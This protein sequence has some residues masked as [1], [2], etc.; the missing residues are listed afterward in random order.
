[1]RNN[2]RRMSSV[3]R[4]NRCVKRERSGGWRDEGLARQ[5]GEG[6]DDEAAKRERVDTRGKEG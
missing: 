5:R 4:P 1:M 2:A 3:E 6:V